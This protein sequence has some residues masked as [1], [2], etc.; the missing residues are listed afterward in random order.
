VHNITFVNKADFVKLYTNF[1]LKWLI[2]ALYVVVIPE[3]GA[4]GGHFKDL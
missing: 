1:V 3:Q 4:F 2:F